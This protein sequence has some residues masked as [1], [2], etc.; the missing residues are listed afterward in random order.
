MFSDLPGV[1]PAQRYISFK[2]FHEAAGLG[3]T[4]ALKEIASGRLPARRCG[5]KILI[6]RA[7]MD[8]WFASL[9]RANGLKR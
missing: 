4:R 3:R 2:Q 9:P 8:A 7:N 5:R 1:E 6:D